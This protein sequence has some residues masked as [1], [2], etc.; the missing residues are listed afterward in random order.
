MTRGKS[1]LPP[2]AAVFDDHGMPKGRII[3]TTSNFEVV[4]TSRS[5][6][7]TGYV[8]EWIIISPSL[9]NEETRSL[10]PGSNTVNEASNILATS[11]H[12]TALEK[13]CIT[14]GRHT[15]QNN[16]EPKDHEY[17]PKPEDF[18]IF[19]D[20]NTVT[21]MMKIFTIPG[22]KNPTLLDTKT[23]GFAL[24][25]NQLPTSM[26]VSGWTAPCKQRNEALL[27]NEF[28]TGVSSTFCR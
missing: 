6:S 21:L 15:R 14:Y 25:K 12:V 9:I 13:I 20:G 11:D 16:N 26:A 7:K 23:T 24:L 8:T 2:A 19:Q 18:H 4:V 17:Y 3:T 1:G 10:M 27:D 5:V 28:W 22:F